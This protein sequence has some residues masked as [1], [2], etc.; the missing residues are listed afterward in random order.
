MTTTSS[1]YDRLGGD[2]LDLA[3]FTDDLYDRILADPLLAPWFGKVPM[4]PQKKAFA[5]F[6]RTALRGEP[7]TGPSLREAHA[8][9]NLDG[10]RI[11]DEEFNAVAGHLKDNLTF[12]GAREDVIEDVLGWAEAERDEVLGRA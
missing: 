8:G 7:W 4:G 11:G 3:A 1:L 2:R 12:Y 5:A 9:L 6:L 10:R